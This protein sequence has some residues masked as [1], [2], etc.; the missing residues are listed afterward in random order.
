M[1]RRFEVTY[2]LRVQ[3][4]WILDLIQVHTEVVGKKGMCLLHGPVGR[5]V[6]TQNLRA[7]YGGGGR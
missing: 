7:G 3:D 4:Y 6:A 2:Y 1:S 5:N